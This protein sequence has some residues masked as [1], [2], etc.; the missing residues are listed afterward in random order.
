LFIAAADRCAPAGGFDDCARRLRGVIALLLVM[1]AVL[2]VLR[3]SV[4]KE[5]S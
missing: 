4:T 3:V 2:H 1:A 5:I